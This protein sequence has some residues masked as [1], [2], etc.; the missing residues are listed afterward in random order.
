MCT[1][2]DVFQNFVFDQELVEDAAH[3]PGHNGDGGVGF[4][5]AGTLL[6]VER[7]KVG[8]AP[9]R[10]PARFDQRPA[11]PLVTRRQES[12]VVDF[13][14]RAMGCRD[15]AGVAAELVRT[16]EAID[17]VDLGP[18]GRRPRLAPLRVDSAVAHN[19]ARA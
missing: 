6:P 18:P 4:F 17:L 14:A 10:D 12:T 8:R 7:S 9:D 1:W 3:P 19:S 11:Q 16:A 13:A 2:A 15:D 5:A